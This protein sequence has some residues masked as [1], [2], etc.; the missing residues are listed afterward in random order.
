MKDT[1]HTV[2]QEFREMV[3]KKSGQ[4]RLRMG[5]SMFD[6]ARNIVISSIKAKNQNADLKTIL[7]E[8]FLRFYGSDFPNNK[9]EILKEIL[10]SRP[11]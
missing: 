4:E 9:K 3:M 6:M 2:Q 10:K 11:S 5:F 1:S 7:S 8:I